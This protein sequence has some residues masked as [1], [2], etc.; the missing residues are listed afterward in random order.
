MTS[1][2]RRNTLD[3]LKLRSLAMIFGPTVWFWSSLLQLLLSR[4]LL[5]APSCDIFGRRRVLVDP[6]SNRYRESK[7]AKQGQR[8]STTV[9]LNLQPS[10]PIMPSNRSDPHPSLKNNISCS[11][12]LN[13]AFHIHSPSPH[14]CRRH[15]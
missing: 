14:F 1:C 6:S 11:K 7:D 13:T 3:T 12:T 9:T 15:G 8:T 2:R 10:S 5:F 4:P